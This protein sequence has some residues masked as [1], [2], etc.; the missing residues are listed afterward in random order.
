MGND[1]V[2]AFFGM[3]K[4]DVP[5]AD[6]DAVGGMQHSRSWQPRRAGTQEMMKR[7]RQNGVDFYGPIPMGSGPGHSIYFFD[8]NGI[9]LEVSCIEVGTPSVIAN[10]KQTK[11]QILHELKT[12]AGAS[13]IVGTVAAA[14]AEPDGYTLLFGTQD[15]LTLLPV[16]KKSLPYDAARDLRPIAEVTDVPLLLASNAAVPAQSLQQ[17]VALA[18]AKPDT[19]K[20]SSAG[21]GG[22]NHLATELFAQTAGIKLA[23]IPYRGGA[24]ATFALVAGEVELMAGSVSL[25]DQGM[26]SGKLR[27]LGIAAKARAER[28]PSVPT[29]QEAGFEGL[30]VSA[31]F[32]IVAPKAISSTSRTCST[33]RSA[34]SRRPP[35]SG[36][37][38]RRRA[39][40]WNC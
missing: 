32:G 12:F 28:A 5:K 16:L 14:Q 10:V 9:P 8:P 6:R 1:S 17:L 22:I 18:K 35:N 29:M 13:G 31:Y 4:N 34:R 21:L 39:A 3:P 24:P 38:S 27:G 33:A 7:L 19:L 23:H 36:S 11:S 37:V 30:V 2:L 20:Y 40:R 25:L 26:V 15:T